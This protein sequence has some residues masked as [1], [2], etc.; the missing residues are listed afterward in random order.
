MPEIITPETTKIAVPAKQFVHLHV[1]TDYSLLDGAS[2]ISWSTRIKDT[3]VCRRKSDLVKM[4]LENNAPAC[5][6]TDHGVM[7]GAIEFYE[8]MG[9]AGIKP[10]I[11]CEV[12][13]APTSKEVHDPSVP[14]IR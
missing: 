5:A 10:I 6:M 8:E 9:A 7:G 2:A 4:C 3:E 12:Y 13:V 14:H 1:H 11:G